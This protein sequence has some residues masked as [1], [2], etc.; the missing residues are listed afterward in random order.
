MYK[1][2]FVDDEKDTLEIIKRKVLRKD[3]KLYFAASAFEAYEV[4]G[5]RRDSSNCNRSKNG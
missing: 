1:I 4:S 2:L 3:F 5:K